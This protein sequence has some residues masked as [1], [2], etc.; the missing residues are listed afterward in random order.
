[1]SFRLD[2]RFAVAASART[3]AEGLELLGGQDAL[4]LDLHLPDLA[5]PELVRAF[6]ARRPDV[7]LILHSAA[8]DAAEVAAVRDLVDAVALK[9]RREE[10]LDAL[11]RLTGA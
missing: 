2:G 10:L 9:G 5:G 8:A 3:A 4:L 6:R 1:M 7:P 11:T